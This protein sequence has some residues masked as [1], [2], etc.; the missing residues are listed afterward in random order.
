MKEST[1]KFIENLKPKLINEPVTFEKIDG[2]YVSKGMSAALTIDSEFRQDVYDA[3]ES[4]EGLFK[5]YEF[6]NFGIASFRTEFGDE[7]YY[8]YLNDVNKYYEFLFFRWE[9]QPNEK[10]LN[11]CKE[12]NI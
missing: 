12:L 9:L 5:F 8:L 3:L 4:G 2:I 6:D 10:I 7:F 11:I 1:C